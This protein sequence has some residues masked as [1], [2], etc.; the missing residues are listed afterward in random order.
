MLPERGC[1]HRSLVGIVEHADSLHRGNLGMPSACAMKMN[2]SSSSSGYGITGWHSRVLYIAV[3]PTRAARKGLL[4][5]LA[6]RHCGACRFTT[7]R[8]PWHAVS[9]CHEDECLELVQWVWY[10][11]MAFSCSLH[12]RRTH[13]CCPKGVAITARL[14]AL[15]SMPIHYIE[16]T[17][18]C[19]QRVP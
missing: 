19:R 5:P 10:H 16:A 9:V 15:W 4:S 13:T 14:S 18:A 6:C 12:R 11:G 7:S 3:G 1:Y 8:Q 2:A 17:L